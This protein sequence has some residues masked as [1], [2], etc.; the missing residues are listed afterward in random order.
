MKALSIRQPWAWLIVNGHKD[1]ENR[2]WTT[3]FR[4]DFLV[5]AS[6]GMTRAEYDDVDLML[7]LD[8]QLRHIKLPAFEHLERGGIVGVA[9]ITDCV[10]RSKSPW[11]FG[12]HGFVLVGAKPAPFAP[13]KGMLGFFDVPNDLVTP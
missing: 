1:I 4:G 10:T 3:R 5:H 7:A 13:L 6:K 12:S 9:T 11:F 8:E 2:S